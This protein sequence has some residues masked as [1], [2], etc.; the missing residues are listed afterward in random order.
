MMKPFFILI[1]MFNTVQLLAEETNKIKYKT[2]AEVIKALKASPNEP[3][4]G[5]F[6]LTFVAMTKSGFNTRLHTKKN[7][8]DP[9]NI[10]VEIPPFMVEYFTKQFKATL[11]DS[12]LNQLLAVNGKI[13]PIVVSEDEKQKTEYVI[14]VYLANQLAHL[15]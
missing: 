3:V 1:L 14:K 7:P 2:A 11:E 13:T 8:Q 12:Y 5:P 10:I 4:Q 6:E 15:Q 9:D